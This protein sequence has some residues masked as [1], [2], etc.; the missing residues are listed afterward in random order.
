MDGQTD[1]WMDGRMEDRRMDRWTDDRMDGLYVLT[2]S[3]MRFRVNPRSIV[4]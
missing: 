4:A 2:M 1:G 3:R